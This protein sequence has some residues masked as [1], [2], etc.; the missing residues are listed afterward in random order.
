MQ[1]IVSTSTQGPP[2]PIPTTLYC[3][4]SRSVLYVGCLYGSQAWPF[5]LATNSSKET[6]YFFL[7]GA[8][9]RIEFVV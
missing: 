9:S 5:W 6:P 2:N 1:I 3:W 7:S 8:F 4:N